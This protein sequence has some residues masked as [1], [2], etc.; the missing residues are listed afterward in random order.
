MVGKT[1]GEGHTMAKSMSG[2]CL[3]HFDR[4]LPAITL[5]ALLYSPMSATAILCHKGFTTSQNSGTSCKTT[6]QT[7]RYQGDS[8]HSKHKPP[9]VTPSVSLGTAVVGPSSD[10][11]HKVT[12][13]A[14]SSGFLALF[15]TR[16][17]CLSY[18]D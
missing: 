4:K 3:P 16:Q 7:H 13:G 6:I 2:S 8:S 15:P 11:A 10:I 5:K 1:W 12:P 18:Q 14:S 17:A 9:H